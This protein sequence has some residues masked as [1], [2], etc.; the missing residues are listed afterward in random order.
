MTG[1]FPE[2]FLA[3]LVGFLSMLV[4]DWIMMEIKDNR[5]NKE[6]DNAQADDK[7]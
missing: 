5:D 6:K 1:I 2:L 4:I 3:Y 7:S